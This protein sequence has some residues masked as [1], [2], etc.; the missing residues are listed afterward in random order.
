MPFSICMTP[1]RRMATA[2]IIVMAVICAA[3]IALAKT[4]A[5]KLDEY[6]T[7][8]VKV[9]HF[10][11]AALVAKDGQVVLAKGYGM[12][13]VAAA[14]PNTAATRF[15]IGSVTKQFT[16]TAIMQLAEKKRLDV[17]DPIAKYF[18]DFPKPAADKITIRNLLTHTSGIPN[19][20][21]LPQY[22][23]MH[24][25]EVR[26]QDIVAMFKDLPLQF[27]PGSQYRYSNSGYF[28]LGLIIEK[29]S[30]ENYQEYL[31]KHIFEPLAMTNSGYPHGAMVVPGGRAVGY[32]SDSTGAMVATSVPNAS[33][34]FS[35][36]S[37]YSTVEDML[38]WDTG[39][40]SGAILTEASLSEMFTP[41]K[42][43]YGYGWIIDTLYGHRM[44]LHDG[45]I[46]GFTSG[47]VRFLDQQ[48]CAVV[49]CNNATVPA[50]RLAMSL[51]AIAMEQPYDIPVLKTPVALDPKK[52]D[53]YIGVYQIDST[54]YRIVIRAGDSLFA[55]RSGS[56]RRRLYPEG[57]DKFYYDFD[58]AVTLTFIRGA[59]SKVVEQ[60]IHQNARDEHARKAE[61]ETAA[62]L[63][64]SQTETTVDPQI[65]DSYAGDYQLAPG[66]I[67]TV[68]RRGNQIFTQATGQQEVEIYPKSE[69]EYFLKVVDAQISFVKDTNGKVTGLVLHQNG[70][71]L[72]GP[73]IK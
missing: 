3:D 50:A 23:T 65:Y 17:N 41:F 10:S 70:R 15:L 4:P 40:R 69:T 16:A 19:F 12:A 62:R 45:A 18:P 6:L 30:G 52:L 9:Q 60:V 28:L 21:D 24:T 56:G 46:D 11:G 73:K 51:T 53:D 35:A 58:N 1:L 5:E 54:Q 64:A 59:G 42:D 29:V 44:V 25:Y 66:F 48:Y 33:V 8:A 36:G 7:A 2:V 26:S 67:L 34:P 72:P 31:L 43:K 20:T 57:K 39:L 37:L 49:F 71:D 61:G 68:R 32:E 14:S 22:M 27:E 13:D 38:K 55:Q 63:L 47:F